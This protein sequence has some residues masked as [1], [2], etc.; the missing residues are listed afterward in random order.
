M[1]KAADFWEI[2]GFC[3]FNPCQ[4]GGSVVEYIGYFHRGYYHV[5]TFQMA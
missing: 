5:R 3:L 1:E 4:E 2:R